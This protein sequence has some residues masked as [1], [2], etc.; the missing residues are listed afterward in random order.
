MKRRLLI[1]VLALMAGSACS[2][3]RAPATPG[4]PPSSVEQGLASWYGLEEAGRATA[5]GELMDPEKLTAAHKSLA[6]GSLV[7]VI[8]LDSGKRVEVIINDR[9]PFVGGRIIDLSFKAARELG[10]VEK[11]VAR[12]RVEV[13]GLAGP[14]AARRW[15]VQTG[16]FQA[17]ARARELLT[18][19]QAQGHSPVMLTEFENEGVRYHRVWVGS[20]RERGGAEQLLRQ[21]QLQGFSGF[22]ILAAAT[23][24]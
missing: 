22:V 8:D 11:G 16:S 13:I 12:V 10:I 17:E 6:F 18:S 19:I 15:R 20:F 5:S 24:P 7:R 1:G 9:G 14:L 4:G 2:G 21:L 3:R 23:S